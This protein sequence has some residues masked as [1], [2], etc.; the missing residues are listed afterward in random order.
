MSKALFQCKAD[1]SFSPYSLGPD[2]SPRPVSS[3][4]FCA[5]ADRQRGKDL[6]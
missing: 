4:V 3:A 6:L 1:L 5:K 2:F